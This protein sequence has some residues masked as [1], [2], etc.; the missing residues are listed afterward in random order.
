MLILFSAWMLLAWT[1]AGIG[2]AFLGNDARY[3]DDAAADRAQDLLILAAWL[4]L[5]VIALTAFVAVLFFPLDEMASAAI[6]AAALLVSGW[7]WHRASAARALRAASRSLLVVLCI[8]AVILA[9]RSTRVGDLD[10]AGGYH[11]SLIGWY[12]EAGIPLGLGLFQWRLATH[13]SWLALTALLDQGPMISRTGNIA[14]GLVLAWMLAHLLI[15]GARIVRGRADKADHFV[16]A[17]VVAVVP[18]ILGWEM[19]L[20][21]S[22]DVPVILLSIVLSWAWLKFRSAEPAARCVLPLLA[23]SAFAVTVKLSAVPLFAVMG[24]LA[25]REGLRE[26]ARWRLLACAAAAP[27]AAVVAASFVSTGCAAFP[28]PVLCADVPWGVGAD[29][30][31]TYA[32][33]VNST[34]PRNIGD[35]LVGSGLAALALALRRKARLD[36]ADWA[37]VAI[38]AVGIAYTAWFAPTTRFGL[39]FLVLLPALAIAHY[40]PAARAAAARRPGRMRATI[41]A[42]LAGAIAIHFAVPLYKEFIYAKL[43]VRTFESLAERKRGDASINAAN[44]YWYLVPNRVGYEGPFVLLPAHGFRYWASRRG[45]CWDHAP[46]CASNPELSFIPALRLRDAARGIGSGFARRAGE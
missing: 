28:S 22:P 25:M 11:W 1:A 32:G 15:A 43:R 18:G 39:G 45:N 29:T 21:P 26:S 40:G 38:A 46:P 13:S 9:E 19:R 6:V 20:S 37:V 27:V 5:A 41:G 44:P 33:I 8:V 36:A 31:R 23:L 42:L 24:A 30:A 12:R 4:G 10:D 16:A 2:L 35:W 14:N 17:A 7:G 34:A 3:D